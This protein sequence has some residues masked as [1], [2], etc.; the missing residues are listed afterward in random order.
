MF[1]KW[2]IHKWHIK[3]SWVKAYVGILGNETADTL[4]KEAATSTDTPERYDKVPISAVK[5]E[6]E[7]LSVKKWQ[8][9][10]DQST[11]GQITKTILPRQRRHAKYETE[12]DLQF[13]P[14]GYWSRQYKFRSPSF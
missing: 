8:R 13:H 9:E 1:E 4:A 10:W 5:S 14:Y 7:V 12:T 3:F 11:K 6:L 2:H